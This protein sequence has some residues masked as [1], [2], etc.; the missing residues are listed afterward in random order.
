MTKP[1]A[2]ITGGSR[3]IGRATLE[4]LS[5]RGYR[6][7]DLSR[8]AKSSSSSE[9]CDVSSE[10]SVR[11]AFRAIDARFGRIDALVNCAGVATFGGTLALSALDWETVFQINT[12]GTF[13][14]CQQAL[15]RMAKRRSGSIVNVS[16]IAGR[17]FSRTASVAYTASKY[18]VIGLTRQLAFEFAPK[19]IRVN[20]VAPSQTQTE[21][22]VKNFSKAQLKKIAASL[23]QGR[24]AKPSEVASVIA[25]LVGEKS[26]YMNGAVLD[27]NG[28]LL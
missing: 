16:S 24:L 1:V 9:P 6:A 14:C 23:P 2:V 20:C 5:R 8:H 11:S 7:V 21:M 27:V 22:L 19:G 17:S 10:V 15:Q 4:L 12:T 28:G 26:A 3:G 18:A 13:L 25:F